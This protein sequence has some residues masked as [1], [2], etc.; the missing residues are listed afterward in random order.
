MWC[1]VAGCTSEGL[2]VADGRGM[3]RQWRISCLRRSERILHSGQG[4]PKSGSETGCASHGHSHAGGRR[5]LYGCFA[6][7]ARYATGAVANDTRSRCGGTDGSHDPLNVGSAALAN[8]SGGRP[9][10]NRL[11]LHGKCAAKEVP[12]APGMRLWKAAGC[13]VHNLQSRSESATTRRC[14]ARFVLY[15]ITCSTDS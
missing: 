10:W 9:R 1:F 15:K 5:G 8:V 2:P 14:V 12:F 11:L 13:T 4:S 3:R 7:G 6:P